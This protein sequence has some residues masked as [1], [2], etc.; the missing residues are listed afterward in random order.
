MSVASFADIS[1][2]PWVVSWAFLFCLFRA[3]PVAFQGSQARD[4][5][6]AVAAS[7]RHSHARSKLHLPSTPQLMAALDSSIH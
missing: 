5:I 6:R 2:I 1:P 3:A 4:Q 7:L